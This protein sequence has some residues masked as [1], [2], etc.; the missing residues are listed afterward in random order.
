MYTFLIRRQEVPEGGCIF[1]VRLRVSL[2]GMY[3]GGEFDAVSY[4]EHGCIIA[5]HVPISLLGIELDRETARIPGRITRSLLSADSR[6][7]NG[8][9]R[10]LA[11][12]A[13]D[14]SI[15][16]YR[17]VSACLVSRIRQTHNICYVMRD[18]KFS[19]CACTF[20]MHHSF[21]NSFPIEMG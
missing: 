1:E 8:D 14:I 10:F 11:D 12:L 21:W 20:G 17:L 2:L 16:L 6:K 13:E 3:E 5:N 4:E 18:L 9:F 7:P 15:T 19:K